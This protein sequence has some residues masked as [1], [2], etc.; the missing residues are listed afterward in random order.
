MWGNIIEIIWID[1]KTRME[2]SQK[3]FKLPN[4]DIYLFSSF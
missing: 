2:G 4:I 3:K 1:F